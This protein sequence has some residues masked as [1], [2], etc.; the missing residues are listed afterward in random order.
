[1]ANVALADPE[2]VLGSLR[3]LSDGLLGTVQDRLELVSIEL[4]E[5]KLRLIQTFVWI[6]PAVVAGMMAFTFAGLTRV[7]Y[8]LLGTRWAVLRGLTALYT[9]AFIVIVL[10]DRRFLARQPVPFAAAR[11][12]TGAERA[13]VRDQ[14]SSVVPLG[15]RRCRRA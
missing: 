14:N 9:G 15:K 1:M 3:A 10:T 13:C 11:H 7:Y 5:E 6:S 12:E 8:C 4:H 2:G